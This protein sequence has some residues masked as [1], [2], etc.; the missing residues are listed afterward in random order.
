MGQGV[1]MVAVTDVDDT[2]RPGRRGCRARGGHLRQRGRQHRR[3]AVGTDGPV[4]FTAVF[5][6]L[7]GV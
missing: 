5:L 2:S 4:V 3:A 1:G 6:V 7:A